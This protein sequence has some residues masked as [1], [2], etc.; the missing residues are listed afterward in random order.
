MNARN[1]G[2]PCYILIHPFM[3]KRTLLLLLVLPVLGRAAADDMAKDFAD[4]P[5]RWH[6]R[7]LWFW[8][9]KLEA[10]K[11]RAMVAACKES[12]YY[13]MARR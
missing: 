5:L 13:G 4:S 2:S 8:N 7:P 10:E 1:N 6:S 12:G 9:G 3:I 11:T